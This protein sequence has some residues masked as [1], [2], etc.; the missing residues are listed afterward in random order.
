MSGAPWISHCKPTAWRAALWV[1]VFW[2]PAC[3]CGFPPIF[4][5]GYT[6]LL[7]GGVG[8][9][10]GSYGQGVAR[11]PA[12]ENPLCAQ[13]RGQ[14]GGFNT[15]ATEVCH[16]VPY[17]WQERV[18]RVKVWHKIFPGAILQYLPRVGNQTLTWV[19][20]SMTREVM[21]PKVQQDYRPWVTLQHTLKWSKFH[22]EMRPAYPKKYFSTNP[23]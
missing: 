9:G 8:S 23:R 6:C 5:M 12:V 15:S 20:I 13:I 3:N 14:G 19:A 22:K 1:F 11:P 7:E 18:L 2:R 17:N 10:R 21:W 16:A 4:T